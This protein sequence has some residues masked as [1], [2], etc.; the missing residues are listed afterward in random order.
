MKIIRIEIKNLFGLLDY[1][2]PLDENEIT[3]LTGPN[4]YGKTMILNIIDSILSNHLNFLY[5]LNFEEIILHYQNGVLN[6][7][8]EGKTKLVLVHQGSSDS[9]PFIENLELQAEDQNHISSQ[10]IILPIWLDIKTKNKIQVSPTI[11]PVRSGVLGTL[12]PEGYISFIRAN[13]LE[14]LKN[15][16]TIID[17]CAERLKELMEAAEDE[18]ATLSQKLDATFPFRLFERLQE[19]KG[20]FFSN[21]QQRLIGIQGKRRDYMKFGLLQKQDELLPAESN[22]IDSSREYLNVLDL[23]IDDALEKLSP[24]ETLHQKIALFEDILKEKVLAFK[25]ILISRKEGFIFQNTNGDEIARNMLSTGEQNQVV[26]LFGLI[27]DFVAHKVI[28]IDEPEISLHMA[29]Q[30]TFLDSLEKIQKINQYE[31]VIIATHSAAVIS[32]KWSLMYDLFEHALPA[33]KDNSV[34]DERE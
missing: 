4:G 6:I 14:K 24:F 27:F 3:I 2:I 31:K 5:S 20:L 12:F 16:S 11:T 7:K 25:K 9:A 8:S 33:K 10:E 34:K 18:S 19:Q 1:N 15:G 26:L 23:Y 17:Q 13:R 22:D 21:I 30:K 32:S 28:L 29:W